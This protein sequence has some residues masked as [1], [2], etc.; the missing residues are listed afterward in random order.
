MAV[1]LLVLLTCVTLLPVLLQA[2][3]ITPVSHE[4]EPAFWHDIAQREMEDSLRPRPQGVAKNIIFFLGDGMG[5]TSVTAARILQGQLKGRRGEE[6]KLSFDK[7]PYTGL[8]RTY[9][10]DHQITDSAASG[11]AYLTGVKTNSGLLGLSAAAVR[12]QCNSTAGASVDSILRWS[13]QEGKSAGIVTT[14]RVTHASPGASYAHSADRDWE[15][16]RHIPADQKNCEDIALQLISRNSDIH[17]VLGGGRAAF[18]PEDFE[19]PDPNP[20]FN[21]SKDSRTDGRNLIQEW[22]SYMT[23]QGLK[24]KFV[25]NKTG[26]NDVT[27]A[28]TDFLLGL[29]SQDHMSYE[30][31]RDA[32][33]EPSLSEMTEKAISIL[34][35]NPKGFFLFVEGGRIDHGH[36]ASLAVHALH[37]TVAFAQ[38]V[39]TA[40]TLTDQLDTLTVVTADHSHVMSI[41]GYATRGNP[42]LGL[43]D[44]DQKVPSLATL[45]KKPYTTLLYGTGPGYRETRPNITLENT[46]DKRYI[47]QSAVPMSKETHG[48]EDVG[49]FAQGP[50][51]FLYTGVHEQNYIPMVMAYAS[52]V[53][54]YAEGG[55]PCARH[56]A[57]KDDTQKNSRSSAGFIQANVAVLVFLFTLCSFSQHSSII[58]VHL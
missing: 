4:S 27:A 3:G 31:N 14:A 28:N 34:R 53:G 9:S 30:L 54:P 26:F 36:H 24:H 55:K 41:A 21:T 29:F 35:K 12:K 51:S 22:K 20:S 10:V 8:S 5:P 57:V 16:D 19:D 50:Q 52:C 25:F 49:I 18:Y 7:F 46:A 17:V 39:Q 58:T 32:T 13:L 40:T 47:S 23:S 1:V 37:E 45:D 44:S 43:S 11:T 15:S 56:A 2:A 38:A 48:G 33:K 42:I 6:E